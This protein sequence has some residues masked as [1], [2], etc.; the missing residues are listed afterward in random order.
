[1]SDIGFDLNINNGANYKRT[2]S[3]I[4]RIL[5]RLDRQA[6]KAGDVFDKFNESLRTAGLGAKI[7]ANGLEASAIGLQ[8]I[9]EGIRGI[10][11]QFKAFVQA[12]EEGFRS[13]TLKDTFGEEGQAAAEE[14]LGELKTTWGIASP[15]RVM[16]EYAG[17]LGAGFEQGTATLDFGSQGKNL[18]TTFVQNFGTSLLTGI[19]TATTGVVT[20]I[21]D[22]VRNAGDRLKQGGVDLAA[23]GKQLLQTG[24]QQVLVGGI[25]G[26]VQGQLVTKVADFDAIL[27]QVRVFGHLSQ[28]ELADIEKGILD[29]SARTIFDP[30]QSVAALLDLEKAGLDASDALKVLNATGNLAA[31]QNIS[32][33]DSTRYT[34]IAM[35]TFGL[36]VD[37]VTRIVDSF[38]KSADA[39]TASGADLGEGLANVGPI[40]AQFGLSLEQTLAVLAQF[41]SAGIQGAEAGTQLKSL[42]V[43]IT[44]PSKETTEAFK[45]LGVSLTDAQGKF[46]PLNQVINELKAAMDGVKTVTYT[47]GGA[48]KANNAELVAAQK[49]YAAASRQIMLYNDGLVAGSLNEK[50]KQK[51]LEKYQQIQANAQEVIARLTGDQSKAETITKEISRTQAENFRAIQ[52]LGGSFGGIGLSVLLSGDQDAIDAFVKGLDKVPSAAEIAGEQMNT[53]KGALESLRGSIDALLI[54]AIRPILNNFLKPFIAG[55]TLL[56]NAAAAIPEPILAAAASIAGLVTAFVTLG[57]LMNIVQGG[58]ML[59]VSGPISQLGSALT[60]VADILVNPL[61]LVAAFGNLVATFT[62]L[63]AVIGIGFVAF[64]SL[65]Q[66]V[67]A[68]QTNA[69]GAGDAFNALLTTLG[70]IGDVVGNIVTSALQIFSAIAEK[71]SSVLFGITDIDFSNVTNFFN[72][73]NT[74]AQQALSFLNNVKDTLDFISNAISGGKG[75]ADQQKA[76]EAQKQALKEIS[77]LQGK[78]S[79]VGSTS[80]TYLVKQGDSLIKIAR[81]MNTSV[82]DLVKA[83]GGKRFRLFAGKSINLPINVEDQAAKDEISRLRTLALN[84]Q[85]DI[86]SG[87]Q[88]IVDSFAK[89]AGT[90]FF[91]QLFGEQNLNQVLTQLRNLETTIRRTFDD[92]GNKV[93]DFVEKIIA[94]VKELVGRAVTFI[95]NTVSAIQGSEVGQ[96]IGRFIA[97]LPA[98]FERVRNE[99]V[100]VF[101]IVRTVVTDFFSFKWLSD[102]G[103]SISL[104]DLSPLRDALFHALGALLNPSQLISA[105][106]NL[107]KALGDTISGLFGAIKIDPAQFSTTVS[108]LAAQTLELFRSMAASIGTAIKDIGTSIRGTINA[109][110][111]DISNFLIREGYRDLLN[112]ANEIIAQFQSG[113]ILGALT[114]LVSGIVNEIGVIITNIVPSLLGTIQYEFARLS[115]FIADDCFT[116]LAD[117][118]VSGIAYSI[119]HALNK[120]PVGR[121]IAKF[122][123]HVVRDISKALAPV[124]KELQYLLDALLNTSLVKSLFSALD[125]VRQ[126]VDSTLNSAI[127]DLPKIVADVLGFIVNGLSTIP[128]GFSAILNIVGNAVNSLLALLNR[129]FG[130]GLGDLISTTLPALGSAL[131]SFFGIF[132]S[133]IN[134]RPDEALRGLADVLGSLGTAILGFPVTIAET[135]RDFLKELGAG[136]IADGLDKTV[137]ATLKD[138]RDGIGGF[139]DALKGINIGDLTNLAIFG[140]ALLAL[141]NPITAIAG[142]VAVFTALGIGD[143][144][145]KLGE[146]VAAFIN[147]ISGLITG[148]QEKFLGGIADTVTKLGDA[149]KVLSESAREKIGDLGLGTLFDAVDRVATNPLATG[150]FSG[151]VTNIKLLIDA[152]KGTEGITLGLGKFGTAVATFIE[153]IGGGVRGAL[154]TVGGEAASGLGQVSKF[155]SAFQGF[156]DKLALIGAVLGNFDR[157]KTGISGFFDALKGAN[158]GALL[159]LAGGLLILIN[160]LAALKALALDVGLAVLAGALPGLGKALKDLGDIVSNLFSGNLQ[161]SID[162]FVKFLTDLTGALTEGLLSGLDRLKEIL[163]FIIDPLTKLFGLD[164]TN[165]KPSEVLRQLAVIGPFLGRELGKAFSAAGDQIV[166]AFVTALRGII[167]G[168]DQIIADLTAKVTANKQLDT[169]TEALRQKMSGQQV[170]LSGLQITANADDLAKN[171]SPEVAGEYTAAVQKAVDTGDTKSLEILLPIVASPEFNQDAKDLFSAAL[172]KQI[173]AAY[174]SGDTEKVQ[175]LIPVAAKLG[176]DIAGLVNYRSLSPE[177]VKQAILTAIQTGDT[178]TYDLLMP[179]AVKLKIDK[180]PEIVGTA[181][182]VTAKAQE[183]IKQ[184]ITADGGITVDAGQISVVLN[185]A[186]QYINPGGGEMSEEQKKKLADF[187]SGNLG[188]SDTVSKAITDAFLAGGSDAISK[189]DFAALFSTQAGTGTLTDTATF[190]DFGISISQNLIDGLK[191]GFTDKSPEVQAAAQT[192]ANDF[193]TRMNTE[194]G[195][196]SPSQWAI[197]TAGFIIAGLIEGL[198]SATPALVIPVAALTATFELLRIGAMSAMDQITA[199][200]TLMP[201]Q[202]AAPIAIANAE[203]ATLADAW[204]KVAMQA[205]DAEAAIKRATAASTAGGVPPPAPTGGGGARPP[206]RAQGGP[207]TAGSWF[208]YK[209]GPDPEVYTAADGRQYMLPSKNGYVAR[210]NNAP[211]ST[212]TSNIGGD[213]YA[214]VI[215]ISVGEGANVSEDQMYR[216]AKKAMDDSNRE[217]NASRRMTNSGVR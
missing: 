207:V 34:L 151:L 182:A 35:H 66:I 72:N 149:L 12:L 40:A 20:A 90:D 142:A 217:N 175:A 172:F 168:S 114:K 194:F 84:A 169:L 7:F 127:Y 150:L 5:D 123:R 99:M 70:Q 164:T 154:G 155:F 162:S 180:D 52:A 51:N 210:V 116:K 110:W 38:S 181:D 163:G 41:N 184:Q 36:G 96:A 165:F 28:Q 102:L 107:L 121:E 82:D 133:L 58:I 45:S 157:L 88:S 193:K 11:P 92:I 109:F 156:A 212:N 146:A 115:R 132:G 117:D 9:Y 15:S 216:V 198:L 68:I 76:I 126:V 8:K 118:L 143:A 191:K 209:D 141:T 6:D 44:R 166:L 47:V 153:N 101:E 176:V 64:Q 195:I 106:G 112:F 3:D 196:N 97:G 205:A 83:N 22:L 59:L 74:Y 204:K 53:F 197:D 23:Q 60:F 18:A 14:F 78:A 148:D 73:V 200:V 98:A 37:D 211:V 43:G 128:A 85:D 113:D 171:I 89:V 19:R 213:T 39:S 24:I 186:L 183:V 134:G 147:S 111:I 173:E 140:A 130:A 21:S 187:I 138:L 206:G 55:L 87:G 95:Q 160:P 61:G 215:N 201:V 67:Q 208:Q 124:V 69:N 159:G 139:F 170:D 63:I 25:A 131:T 203:V 26:A 42:L 135:V 46:K 179:V 1:M 30:S 152:F 100:R 120:S 104:P 4:E 214:P 144:L 178:E 79:T 145:P 93:R 167:P 62:P 137:V 71:V 65:S 199:R 202:L 190:A 17:Q 56:V 158:F 80:A 129:V 192:V 10:T 50:T 86:Q 13:G 108:R 49:A 54:K 119:K 174:L 91:K 189:L 33:G 57:G 136:S 77:V 48:T 105:G 177:A 81:D 29:F 103:I 125:T 16:R 122:F 2:L 27:N 31:A 32:L 185:N 94:A 161:G 188:V 75:T